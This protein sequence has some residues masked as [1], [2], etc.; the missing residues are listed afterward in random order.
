MLLDIQFLLYQFFELNRTLNRV[1]LRC[2]VSSKKQ[3]A[4]NWRAEDAFVRELLRGNDGG[5]HDTGCICSK[6]HASEIGNI[7]N[8]LIWIK[9]VVKFV[10]RICRLKDLLSCR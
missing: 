6:T 9:D 3:A 4:L 1:R 7:N 5:G 2:P 8:I 10:V